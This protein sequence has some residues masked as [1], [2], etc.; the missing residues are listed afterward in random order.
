MRMFLTKGVRACVSC[1]AWGPCATLHAPRQCTS[2]L[3]KQVQLQA[4]K[5]LVVQRRSAY[6][7]LTAGV[8]RRD[9]LLHGAL[10][11]TGTPE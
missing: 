8:L 5:F 11:Q 10:A 3:I 7:L 4:D 9:V 6:V 2:A 1:P